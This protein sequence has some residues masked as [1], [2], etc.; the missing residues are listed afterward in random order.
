MKRLLKAQS[1]NLPV[2]LGYATS[3]SDMVQ[4]VTHNSGFDQY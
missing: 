3:G 4:I 1:S 2:G